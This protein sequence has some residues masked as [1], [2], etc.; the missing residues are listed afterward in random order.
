[1]GGAHWHAHD[2]VGQQT[3]FRCVDRLDLG[4][5]PDVI[6]NVGMALG[7]SHLELLLVVLGNHDEGANGQ[8]PPLEVVTF[9]PSGVL[10]SIQVVTVVRLPCLSLGRHA[11]FEN[12]QPR[13]GTMVGV[14]FRQSHLQSLR[15]PE[16][17]NGYGGGCW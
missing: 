14:G 6:W 10:N 7:R 12:S 5:G 16:M 8:V 3:C 11:G 15:C 13:S 2:G 17:E 1:M 9:H 4:A